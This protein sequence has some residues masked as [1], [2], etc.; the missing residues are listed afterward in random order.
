MPH[1]IQILTALAVA[2]AIAAAVLA[3][4][5]RPW[6]TVERRWVAAGWVIAPATGFLS[7]CAV[8]GLWPHW[9]P[10]I[11]LDRLLLIVL[12]AVVAAEL[13]AAQPRVPRGL[14]WAARLIVAASAARVLLHGT[15]YLSNAAGPD[16]RL[17]SATQVWL[18]LAG[19][20]SA[21]GAVWWALV[22][23]GARRP[24]Y[25]HSLSLAVVC[26]AAGATVM[27]S[28]YLSGGQLGLPLAAA[29]GGA[30][31]ASF[32][33]AKPLPMSGAIAFGTV[34]LFSVLVIGRFFGELTTAQA[35]LLFAAPLA[36]WLPELL[37]ACR[38]SPRV[39]GTASMLLVAAIA[40][41]IVI[42][43]QRKFVERSAPGGEAQQSASG[44]D[45]YYGS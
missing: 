40:A 24:G 20:A 8:L 11:D 41:G 28:G 33:L 2:A 10:S 32:A 21:L 42:A 13:L 12:P 34:M 7:G 44:E 26:G 15:I 3:A 14:V 25:S 30:T 6:S 17:W 43:A 27:L 31:I 45:Q 1:P 5:A 37:P 35:C 16:S 9:P 18:T 39:R 23:L 38:L 4:F 19:L 36:G 29:L 22:S